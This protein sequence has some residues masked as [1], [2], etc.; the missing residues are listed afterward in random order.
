MILENATI[1]DYIKMAEEKKRVL[2]TLS[3]DKAEELE[4]ISKEMGISKSALVSLWIAEN[5][6]K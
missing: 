2:L 5:S 1:T 6:R 4:T 3:L